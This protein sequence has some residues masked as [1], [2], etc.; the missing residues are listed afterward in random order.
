MRR[1][2]GLFLNAVFPVSTAGEAEFLS[3][4]FGLQK[5]RV[6]GFSIFP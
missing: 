6:E 3:L 5:K 2:W 1:G 4:G